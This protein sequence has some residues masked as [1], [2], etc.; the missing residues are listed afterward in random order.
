MKNLILTFLILNSFWAF[1]QNYT[2]YFTGDTTDVVTLTKG[3]ICLMGGA[4]EDDSAMVWFLKQS[5]GGDILVLR[6]TGSNGY[7]TYLYS[8]LGVSVNSVETIVIPSVTAANASYVVKQI[9]NAEAVWIAGGNQYDYVQFW[10]NTPVETE[11]NKLIANKVPIGGTSAGMAIQGRAYN[12]AANGTVTSSEA[13]TNPYNT[14]VSIGYNDFLLHPILKNVIT[15]THYDRPDDANNPE[16]KGRHFTFLARLFQQTNKRFYGIACEEYTAVCI[17]SSGNAR[18]FGG[19]PSYD[20]FAYFLVTNCGDSIAPE[21]CSAGTALT[22]DRNQAAVFTYKVA[23]T[24][25]G[26][27]TFSLNDWKTAS[28]GI[29][30]NWYAINGVLT[31]T[32]GAQAPN[33]SATAIASPSFT[34]WTITPNPAHD[35][36]NI[37]LPFS[38]GEIVILDAQGRQIQAIPVHTD[39][40]EISVSNLAKGLYF[41]KVQN[42]KGFEIQKL[43][44]E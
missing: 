34:K 27:H 12:D 5:G 21:I 8:Q 18:I 41:L 25:L 38:Q 28:G 6:A 14:K 24:P 23:G 44:V 17:D 22:W 31:T 11:L 36:F 10:K 30:E 16:R 1:S 29:W 9:R 19:Y 32:A 33:C 40:I 15:D 4:T 37:A 43:V 13:L 35:L 20:D 7:N 42:E 3:G 2:S 39:D 26:T